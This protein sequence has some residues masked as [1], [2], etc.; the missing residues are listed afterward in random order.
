MQAFAPLILPVI[1]VTV[2]KL[3]YKI[4]A[5]RH[6]DEFVCITGNVMIWSKRIKINVIIQRL[7]EAKNSSI[8]TGH[9]E[10]HK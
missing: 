4:N 2:N 3:N 8:F 9:A 7:E 10:M 1:R 5:S 6:E